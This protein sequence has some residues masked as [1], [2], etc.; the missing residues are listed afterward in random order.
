M[1]RLLTPGF[2][3]A[4]AAFA[5]GDVEHPTK[6]TT[7]Q[8]AMLLGIDKSRVTNDVKP[9]NQRLQGKIHWLATYKVSGEQNCAITITLYPNDRIK[10]EFIEK[11]GENQKESQKVI[12]NDGDVIY[13][14]LGDRGDQGTFYRTTLINHEDDWDVTLILAREPSVD[15][16]KLPFAIA[17][18]GVKLIAEIEALLRKQEAEQGVGVDAGHAP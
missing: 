8:V 1:M 10:T 13:H 16:T 11:I 5:V 3:L 6:P 12:R 2:L 18:D 9:L 4:T 7:A 15:E 14:S 17:K